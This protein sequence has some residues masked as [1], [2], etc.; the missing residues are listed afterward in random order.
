MTH[1][2]KQVATVTSG[3]S[4]RC[5]ACGQSVHGL[6]DIPMDGFT[7]AVN[8][9]LSHGWKLLHVGQQTQ[10]SLGQSYESTVAVLGQPAEGH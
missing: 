1:D 2:M 8:H 4:F 5:P 9:C 6:P 7:K 3:E 10:G